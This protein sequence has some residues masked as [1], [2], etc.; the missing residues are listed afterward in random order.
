MNQSLPAPQQNYGYSEGVGNQ[1]APGFIPQRSIGAPNQYFPP[2]VPFQQNIGQSYN[3]G[4]M[5]E[6]SF[7]QRNAQ[8]SLPPRNQHPIPYFNQGNNAPPVNYSF[9][10]QP[11]SVYSTETHRGPP[12]RI[13]VM[14][15]TN[16]AYS[17]LITAGQVRNNLFYILSMP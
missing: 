10:P 3:A 16:D 5:S 4:R 2:P 13:Q 14:E 11:Q 6:E 15:D 17:T 12:N 9:H 1:E 8:Y 7:A